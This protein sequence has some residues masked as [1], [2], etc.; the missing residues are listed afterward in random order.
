MTR[1]EV[2]DYLKARNVNFEQMCC[3][4]FAHASV[5]IPLDDLTKIGEE[6]HPWY[7]SENDV[8]V[9]F[10]FTSH[11]GREAEAGFKA[12]NSDTLKAVSI[13]HWLQGCL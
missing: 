11:P 3:V 10:Q 4:D 8:Y 12:A 5:Q 2:E 6:D 13:Y 7:C 1:K 9:A